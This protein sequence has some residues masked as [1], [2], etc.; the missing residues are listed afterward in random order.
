[1]IYTNRGAK[2]SEG[3]FLQADLL[4]YGGTDDPFWVLLAVVPVAENKG[5]SGVYRGQ[6]RRPK[7]N[8]LSPPK[9]HQFCFLFLGVRSNPK[10][11]G[12]QKVI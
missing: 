11:A 8:N 12:R 5:R 2:Q 6:L 9:L 4:N 7:F 3:A 10:A 1:L